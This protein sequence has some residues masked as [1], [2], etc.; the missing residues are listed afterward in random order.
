MLEVY[1][2][3]EA[4]C[5]VIILI[6]PYIQKQRNCPND[7]NDAALTLVFASARC[8]G[9]PELRK[10]RNLFGERYGQ[11]FNTTAL[12]LLPGNLVNLTVSFLNFLLIYHM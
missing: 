2:L 12:D 8:G 7:I 9:L 3:L 1:D 4:F 6:F 5:E 10:L 11:E